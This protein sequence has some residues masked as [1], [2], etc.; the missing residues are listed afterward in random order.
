ML[1]TIS[2]KGRVTIPMRVRDAL[3]LQPG[4]VVEFSVNL[5]SEVVFHQWRPTD[6]GNPRK[7]RFEAVRSHAEMRWRTD[8]LMKLLS[9]EE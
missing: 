6:R 5:A 3:R 9:A 8:H 2:R 7:D 1:A 4:A